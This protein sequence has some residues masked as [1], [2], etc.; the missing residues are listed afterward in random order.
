MS[1]ITNNKVKE[2][3]FNDTCFYFRIYPSLKQLPHFSSFRV[4]GTYPRFE[5]ITCSYPRFETIT[6]VHILDLRQLLVF[7]S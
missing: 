7:I 4:L 3:G 1:S 2:L 6:R 5:T